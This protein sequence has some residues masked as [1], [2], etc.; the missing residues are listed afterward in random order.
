MYTQ[1][2]GLQVVLLTAGSLAADNLEQAV[3]LAPDGLALDLYDPP[4]LQSHAI[5]PSLK[6]DAIDTMASQ[7]KGSGS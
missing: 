4:V 5:A 6:Q 2:A 1:K 3:A 7:Q